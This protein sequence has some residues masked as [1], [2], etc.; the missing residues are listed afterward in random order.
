E[1]CSIEEL[2]GGDGTHNAAVARD[3]LDGKA[4]PIRDAVLLNSAAALVAFDGFDSQTDLVAAMRSAVE[5]AAAAIDDGSAARRLGRW[6]ELRVPRA[7]ARI[8][9]PASSAVGE[10][11]QRAGCSASGPDGMFGRRLLG[12][13]SPSR[14]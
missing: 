1:T 10:A 9:A 3:L 7:G 5:R 13:V 11:G 6:A 4:G 12:A 14:Q 2:R 8:A